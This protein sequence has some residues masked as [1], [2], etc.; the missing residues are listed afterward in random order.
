MVEAIP[1]IQVKKRAITIKTRLLY[2][3]HFTVIF[4]FFFFTDFSSDITDQLIIVPRHGEAIGGGGG[5]EDR[6][7]KRASV[8][9]SVTN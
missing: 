5:G 8:H 4:F 9:A 6:N 2:S 3:F 1:K 7:A